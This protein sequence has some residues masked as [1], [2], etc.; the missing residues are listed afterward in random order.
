M[1]LL[2]GEAND[3]DAAIRRLAP[4]LQDALRAH[5]VRVDAM[6]RWLGTWSQALVGRALGCNERTLRDRLDRARQRLRLEL[7]APVARPS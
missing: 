3:T 6:G 7:D 2:V 5:Y 1:P 4:Q